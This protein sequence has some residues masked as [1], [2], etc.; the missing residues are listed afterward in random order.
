VVP[1]VCV[2]HDTHAALAQ[3][4]AALAEAL[5]A[6]VTQVDAAE[7]TVPV[8]IAPDAL[9]VPVVSDTPTE[10]MPMPMPIPVPPRIERVAPSTDASRLLVQTAPPDT[11]TLVVTDDSVVPVAGGGGA[12]AVVAAAVVV[13]VC[14]CVYVRRQGC[15]CVCVCVFLSSSKQADD[16]EFALLVPAAGLGSTRG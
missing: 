13:M 1:D 5:E 4:V 9:A 6:Q 10:P 12:L 16:S 8:V 15:V 14:A 2:A 3:K 7:T 11:L